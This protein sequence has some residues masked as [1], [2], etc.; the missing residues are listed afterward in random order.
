MYC[1][2]RVISI[3]LT[4]LGG[5][6]LFSFSNFLISSQRCKKWHWGLVCLS[7]STF[8]GI[9]ERLLCLTNNVA[10]IG[11]TLYEKW[12]GKI[13]VLIVTTEVLEIC[14]WLM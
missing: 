14:M 2:F 7:F 12:E 8:P 10:F 3:Q 4:V 6:T 9:K 11:T 1:D 13:N 5:K